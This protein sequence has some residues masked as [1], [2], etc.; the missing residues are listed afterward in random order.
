MNSSAIPFAISILRSLGEPDE[1]EDSDIKGLTSSA[2]NGNFRNNSLTKQ[3]RFGFSNDEYTYGETKSSPTFY[4]SKSHGTETRV[5]SLTPMVSHSNESTTRIKSDH[6]TSTSPS[7]LGSRSFKS[8]STTASNTP[9]RES[10]NTEYAAYSTPGSPSASAEAYNNEET[11]RFTSDD[12]MTTRASSFSANTKYSGWG[13]DS[14]S[15]DSSHGIDFALSL[16]SSNTVT[17]SFD[18]IE[19][20]GTRL[21]HISIFDP[22][23]NTKSLSFMLQPVNP[24]DP[25]EITEKEDAMMEIRI[26]MMQPTFGVEKALQAREMYEKRSYSIPS[27]E[28]SHAPTAKRKDSIKSYVSTTKEDYESKQIIEAYKRSPMRSESKH[29]IKN[30]RLNSDDCKRAIEDEKWSQPGDPRISDKLMMHIV[31]LLTDIGTPEDSDDDDVIVKNNDD[32]DVKKSYNSGSAEYNDRIRSKHHMR[33]MKKECSIKRDELYILD[34]NTTYNN[35]E[36]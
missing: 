25:V 26:R 10:F 13:A 16:S 31:Q 36:P 29:D 5:R 4:R 3:T 21:R 8:C 15:C 27:S 34:P 12:T 28:E 7:D 33:S 23:K 22:K 6:S 30:S 9:A 1:E 32:D 20:S 35:Y 18:E 17:E 24:A 11:K 14:A 19:A 2:S